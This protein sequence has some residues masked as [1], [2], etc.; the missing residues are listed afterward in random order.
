[1]NCKMNEKLSWEGSELKGK[2][3]IDFQIFKT[4]H[5][6]TQMFELGLLYVKYLAYLV[7]IVLLPDT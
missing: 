1:M 3:F 6:P 4:L 5:F 7:I 2:D